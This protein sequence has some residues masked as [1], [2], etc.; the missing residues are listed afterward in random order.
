MYI[1]DFYIWK[2]NRMTLFCN[3]F[4]ERPSYLLPS[5][6]IHVSNGQIR[7]A[8]GHV[9]VLPKTPTYGDIHNDTGLRVLS[10]LSVLNTRNL[11]IANKSR[12]ASYQVLPVEYDNR[13]NC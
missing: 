12:S 3:L 5:Q 6:L 13:N 9:R 1:W 10:F 8:Q 11:A 4:I 2:T 7:G